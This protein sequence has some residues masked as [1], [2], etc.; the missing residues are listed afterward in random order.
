MKIKSY[1]LGV[2]RYLKV[3]NNII[4]YEIRDWILGFINN[5]TIYITRIPENTSAYLTYD[6]LISILGRVPKGDT[7]IELSILDFMESVSFGEF[8]ISSVRE[9]E[10]ISFL[11]TYKSDGELGIPTPNY[12]NILHYS[13]DILY[14]KKTSVDTWKIYLVRISD[15]FEEYFEIN[16]LDTEVEDNNFIEPNESARA[17][18]D[19]Y[20]I[21]LDF[22]NISGS[23]ACNIQSDSTVS[24]LFYTTQTT[25]NSRVESGT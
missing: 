15:I 17:S 8:V 4:K 6:N 1:R 5:G 9:D 7:G 13:D 20:C 21:T 24:P 19:D 25:S 11:R 18:A 22:S 12:I 3:F 16:Q 14:L 10:I 23:S 2:L